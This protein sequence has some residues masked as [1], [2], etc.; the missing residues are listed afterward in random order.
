MLRV[1]A[2]DLKHQIGRQIAK[3]RMARGLTQEGLAELTGRSVEAI[4]NIERGKSFPNV[5]TLQSLSQHLTVQVRD[6][7]EATSSSRTDRRTRLETRAHSVLH[8]LTDEFL[9]IAMEQLGALKKHGS[10][11]TAHPRKR[12]PRP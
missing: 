5:E 1:M 2:K 12:W 7:F 4:S 9:E 10:R 8:S 11:T 6:F 3:A